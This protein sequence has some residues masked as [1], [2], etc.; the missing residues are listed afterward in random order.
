MTLYEISPFLWYN[1]KIEKFRYLEIG[2]LKGVY[3]E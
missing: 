2:F 1:K 3:D